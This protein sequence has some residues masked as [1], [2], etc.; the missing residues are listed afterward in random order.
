M[1]ENKDLDEFLVSYLI[2]LYLPQNEQA[3]AI[4]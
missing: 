1:S 4:K 3:T 2:Q